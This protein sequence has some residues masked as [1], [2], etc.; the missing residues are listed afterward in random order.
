NAYTLTVDVRGGNT[1]T[2][3]PSD[4]YYRDDNRLV[5][6]GG[7]SALA[8]QSVRY[9]GVWPV[10]VG[11]IRVTYSAGYNEESAPADVRGA[12]IALAC[13]WFSQRPTFAATE[14]AAANDDL[15][16]GVAA[17]IAKWKVGEAPVPPSRLQRA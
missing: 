13:K 5:Y 2:T 17:T 12:V 14:A 10:G 16:A 9:G 15:P 4:Y 6:T 7:S 1:W 8:I 3:I 11:N